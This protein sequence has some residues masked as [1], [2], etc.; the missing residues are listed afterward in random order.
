MEDPTALLVRLPKKRKLKYKF[1]FNRSRGAIVI[2]VF[3][4][5]MTIFQFCCTCVAIEMWNLVKYQTDS[6]NI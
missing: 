5:L 3:G 4:A 6:E 1:Q 2:I